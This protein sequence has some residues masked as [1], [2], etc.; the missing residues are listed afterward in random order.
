MNIEATHHFTRKQRTIRFFTFVLAI[1][2][3]M[4]GNILTIAWLNINQDSIFLEIIPFGQLLV[5]IPISIILFVLVSSL[6]LFLITCLCFVQVI[7]DAASQTKSWQSIPSW[8]F[9]LFFLIVMIPLIFQTLT[10]I[11]S[12]ATLT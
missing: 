3:L 4:V 1:T 9:Y 2:F 11:Q 6:V 8:V 5:Q 7:V 12:I 10:R